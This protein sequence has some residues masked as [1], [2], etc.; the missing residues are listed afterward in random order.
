M[1]C[2]LNARQS[3]LNSQHRVRDNYEIRAGGSINRTESYVF[4]A[5][6]ARLPLLLAMISILF[7]VVFLAD[8]AYKV[9][10]SVV[11]SILVS[12]AIIFYLQYLCWGLIW[13]GFGLLKLLG[14][15]VVGLSNCAAWPLWAFTFVVEKAQELWR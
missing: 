10:P 2:N 12:T 1:G 3:H 4:F 8:A 6:V 14:W 13:I 15:L 5:L 11:L 7:I 9:S